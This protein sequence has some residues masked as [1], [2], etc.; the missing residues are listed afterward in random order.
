MTINKT[1]YTWKGSLSKRGKTTAVI[2]HHRAGNGDAMSIHKL[3][4]SNGWKGIGYHFYVR[5]DGSVYEG[6]PIDTVGAHAG[7]NNSYSVGVCFEGNFEKEKMPEIQE[8]AGR[9]LLSYIF[10]K[11]GKL[12]VKK[13]SDVCATAC[14]G[15]NFPFEEIAAGVQK[16]DSGSAL[17]RK[18]Q[19]AVNKDGAGIE[20]DGKFGPESLKAASKYVVKRRAVHKY[21]NTT[22]FVQGIVG[23]E[24]DG[25]CGPK[26][27]AAII[28][29]QKKHGLTPDG[30]AGPKTIRKMLGV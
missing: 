8:K 10:G 14:P 7:G 9:E 12:T 11:Y 26:T 3:H 27:K 25:K 5:K 24:A 1:G 13:H 29:Y 17:V 30:S 22:K 23:V 15:R 18:W 19:E 2:L 28:A 16:Q 6:R 4:L 20:V 21:P